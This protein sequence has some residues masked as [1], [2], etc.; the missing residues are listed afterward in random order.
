MPPVFR[1]PLDRTPVFLTENH[2]PHR[3]HCAFVRQV[4]KLLV[5]SYT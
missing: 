1:V 2:L 4:Q 3:M 5:G